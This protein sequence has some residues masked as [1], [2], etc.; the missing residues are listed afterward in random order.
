MS[1]HQRQ[2][3]MC[4]SSGNSP[5]DAARGFSW[6]TPAHGCAW[7]AADAEARANEL[8]ALE[9]EA[10]EVQAHLAEHRN[11]IGVLKQETEA[12]LASAGELADTAARKE[13][14]LNAVSAFTM[15][16]TVL[17]GCTHPVTT[18]QRKPIKSSSQRS[19][20][21]HFCSHG[22]ELLSLRHADDGHCCCHRH[23]RSSPSTRRSG[24]RALQ[25]QH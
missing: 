16:Q 6:L 13:A 8:R 10:A 20:M 17:H 5:S 12:K 14:E 18:L 11:R 22:W 4:K 7:Q 3:A 9:A 2:F 25:R 21:S 24:W 19:V 23:R 1:M 15:L